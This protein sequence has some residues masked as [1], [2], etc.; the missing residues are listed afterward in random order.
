MSVDH[1]ASFANFILP[2]VFDPTTFDARVEAVDLA[3]YPVKGNDINVWKEDRFPDEEF[4]PHIA[5]YL[6]PP[7]EAV[8]TARIWKLNEELQNVFGLGGRAEWTMVYS[9]G[10]IRFQFGVLGRGGV[11]VQLAMF[12]A[13][14]GFLTAR[15]IPLGDSLPDWLDFLHY[16]RFTRGQ[17]GVRV[18]AAIRKGIDPD[19]REP[20]YSSFFPEPAGG[21][22]RLDADDTGLFIDVLIALLDR[23]GLEDDTGTWWRYAFIPGQVIPFAA[24]FIDGVPEQE[25]QR[26]AYRLRNFFHSHQEIFPTKE[27]LRTDNDALMNYVEGQWFSFSLDGGSFIAFEAARNDFFRST[28]PNHLGKQ[29]FLLFLLVLHQRYTLRS[30]SEDVADRCLDCADEEHR[31]TAFRQIQGDL[32]T[33]TAR[34]FF[35]QVGQREHHHR[36]Y[37]KWQ[38]ILCIEALLRE[39]R[40]EVQEIHAFSLMRLSEEIEQMV[41]A[42][43]KR[44]KRLEWFLG[45]IAWLIGIPALALTF[46]SAIAPV[47]IATAFYVS[48]GA[49]VFGATMFVLVHYLSKRHNG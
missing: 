49:L 25:H 3:C 48:L 26:L 42:E 21:L 37:R 9:G 32:L 4:L 14:V 47:S 35:D 29:Y 12:R 10:Q 41:E 17:T 43:K 33:F 2:F 23:A 15:V 44:S 30:I 38:E 13:G 6:N 16:F 31:V 27:D 28:L 5:K 8:A 46:L 34:G 1:K 11:T 39:V 19:I 22:A 7:K 45:M 40:E 18:K 36:Y 20:I 24:L